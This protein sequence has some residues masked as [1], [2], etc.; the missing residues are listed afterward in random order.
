[1]THRPA[2]F[3][4]LAAAL[5][6]IAALTA[7]DSNPTDPDQYPRQTRILRVDVIPNP[8]A[9]GDTVTFI[10]V[11]ADS[12][13]ERFEFTWSATSM[14]SDTTT[15]G[16]VFKWKAQKYPNAPLPYVSFSVRANNHTP[17]SVSVVQ[18]FYVNIVE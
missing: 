9:E 12:L 18:F 14:L 15:Q 10:C 2:S 17:N 7:C 6:M 16:P 3:L 5:L 11:I 8:V 13:D 1:M 4:P